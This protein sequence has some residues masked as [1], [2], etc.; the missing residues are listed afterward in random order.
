MEV[1]AA[2]GGFLGDFLG[3]SVCEGVAF[4]IFVAGDPV[5]GNAD[6]ILRSLSTYFEEEKGLLGGCGNQSCLRN[7]ML[8]FRG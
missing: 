8:T 5:E 6:P 1:H 2:V 7:H 3:D 4:H